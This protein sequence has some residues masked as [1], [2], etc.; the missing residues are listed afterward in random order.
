[1]EEKVSVIIWGQGQRGKGDHKKQADE[2]GMRRELNLEEQ[3][4]K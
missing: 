1:M 3:K 4:E 2:L